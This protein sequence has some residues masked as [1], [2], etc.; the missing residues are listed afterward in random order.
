M[1]LDE[2]RTRDAVDSEPKHYQRAIPAPK[3]TFHLPRLSPRLCPST[4]GCSPPSMP[5]RLLC[6][7]LSCPRWFPQS[8]LCRLA[9]FHLVVRLISFFILVAPL[10]SIWSAY[11]PSFLLFV[12]PLTAFVLIIFVRFLI[13]EHGIL[14]GSFR[15]NIFHSIAL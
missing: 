4:A 2:D 9:I 14:S 3:H 11:C 15:F 8:L 5:A 1:S 13:F 12:R 6:L 10:C 7:L